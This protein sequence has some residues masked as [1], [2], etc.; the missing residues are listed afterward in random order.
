VSLPEPQNR[1]ADE[2]FATVI[3]VS[4]FLFHIRLWALA[5]LEQGF[6][7]RGGIAVGNMYHSSSQAV[8]PALVR[9]YHT[10]LEAGYPRIAVE[11]DLAL[12]LSGGKLESLEVIRRD[13]DG[14]YYLDVLAKNPWYSGFPYHRDKLL[15]II[16]KNLADADDD[17][18]IKA[19]S[20]MLR[21]LS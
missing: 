2:V 16:K 8:G 14:I 15:Q 21:H 7:T 12:D 13:E 5:L 17:K 19:W 20:W 11:R 4:I 10:Y 3:R 6:A 1:G 18:K 9:A